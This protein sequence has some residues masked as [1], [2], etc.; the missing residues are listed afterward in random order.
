MLDWVDDRL[1]YK[2]LA[3]VQI[4]APEPDEGSPNKGWHIEGSKFRFYADE[5]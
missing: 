5:A 1:G 2:T 4:E 3:T